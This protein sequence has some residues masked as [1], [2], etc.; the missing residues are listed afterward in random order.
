MKNTILLCVMFLMVGCTTVTLRPYIGEQQ[1]WPTAEGSICTIRWDLPVFN[2]L[3]PADYDVIG[4]LRVESFWFERPEKE[5]MSAIVRKAIQLEADAIILVGGAFFTTNYGP[6]KEDFIA[7]GRARSLSRIN[8]FQTSWL[9]ANIVAVRWIGDPPPGLPN[10]R[11]DY[12]LDE[13]ELVDEAEEDVPPQADPLTDVPAVPTADP[14]EI[15]P[16]EEVP[17][18]DTPPPGIPEI[19]APVI[20]PPPVEVPAV[21]PPPVPE[22]KEEVLPGEVDIP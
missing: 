11:L 8:S 4:E 5:H 15:A 7:D 20:E 18:I 14:I 21:E 10:R 3:P 17:S 13:A 9:R 1:A 19:E 12:K 16:V 22:P 2:S 6:R